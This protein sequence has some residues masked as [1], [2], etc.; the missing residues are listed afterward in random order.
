MTR[1][2]YNKMLTN[3]TCTSSTGVYLPSV[4]FVSPRR[5]QAN[6]PQYSPDAWLVRGY[7]FNQQPKVQVTIRIQ[8]CLGGTFLLLRIRLN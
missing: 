3:Q 2:L 6:I 1:V 5:P 4:V 7:Y 8:I